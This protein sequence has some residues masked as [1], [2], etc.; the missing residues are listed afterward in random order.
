MSE[1]NPPPAPLRDVSGAPV[2]VKVSVARQPVF[3][4]KFQ[5]RAWELLYRDAPDD[6]EAR[7]D[8]GAVA[9]ARVA[10]AALM[11][12]GLERLAGTAPVHVNL[13]EALVRRAAEFP[14]PLPPARVVLEVLED[15]HV[16]A[17]VLEG[18]RLLKSAGY[19][20]TL[21]DFTSARADGRLLELV[22]SVKVDLLA[23]PAAT[24]EASTRA[25]QAR[26]L[27]LIAEKIETREQFERCVA[28]GFTGFQGYFLQR[29]ETFS[30]QRAP[31]FRLP[32]MQVLA[33][34]QQPDYTAEQL[35]RLV[36][37]DLGLVHRLLRCLN[38]GFYNLPRRVTSIRHAIVILGRDNLMR[39]CAAVAL[40]EFR[41]RPEWLLVN[42]LVRAR[43]CELLA[44]LRAGREVGGFFFAG[45]LSHLDALLGVPTSQAISDLPLTPS[46]EQAL[47]AQ[48]GP[49]G[50]TLRSVQAWE[51]G[52]FDGVRPAEVDEPRLRYA[53]LEAVE[54]AE[55]VRPLLKL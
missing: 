45:L 49:I 19:R 51:R 3:D 6:T 21:D 28:L 35:E 12:I 52:R 14:L 50:E 18:L 16:D 40:A 7:I 34:L 1:L 31:T 42:A 32:A 24:L 55:Q 25:L 4:A 9:T 39:L 13:P 17:E 8:D 23:E 41:D 53:Y 27:E 2:P 30:G 10:I 44:P 43:M 29:P 47:V 37:Q 38:S 15:I 26:G 33:A 22:D 46:V 48:S 20:L 54:W 36:S 11:D 5:V